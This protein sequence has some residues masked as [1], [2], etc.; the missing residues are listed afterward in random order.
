M[1]FTRLVWSFILSQSVSVKLSSERII[2]HR[3]VSQHVGQLSHVPL[4]QVFK[5]VK[6]KEDGDV[7]G[8]TEAED[9]HDQEKNG[10]GNEAIILDSEK[11]WTNIDTFINVPLGVVE[12]NGSNCAD[13]DSN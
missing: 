13:D 2:S 10:G 7:E 9:D 3:F 11:L 4:F 8:K 12:E 5:Q 1:P 6:M